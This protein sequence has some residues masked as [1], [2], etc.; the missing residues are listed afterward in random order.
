MIR[1][2]RRRLR[3]SITVSFNADPH[4]PYIDHE[5]VIPGDDPA[6]KLSIGGGRRIGGAGIAGAKPET[7]DCGALFFGDGLHDSNLPLMFHVKQAKVKFAR[8]AGIRRGL[9]NPGA[10][11]V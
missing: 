2:P 9:W 3:V 10:C 7:M 6:P 1:R 5:T 11:R 8:G 4:A